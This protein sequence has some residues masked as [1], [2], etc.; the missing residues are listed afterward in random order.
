MYAATNT[1]QLGAERR[2][3]NPITLVLQV[4]STIF[5][6]VGILACIVLNTLRDPEDLPG[7]GSPL[8]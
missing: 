2:I 6:S 4:V 5:V 8:P 1:T 3:I 7:A